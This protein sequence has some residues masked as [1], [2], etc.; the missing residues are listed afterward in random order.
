MKIMGPAIG[1]VRFVLGNVLRAARVPRL[2]MDWAAI[3]LEQA[4]ELAA[5]CAGKNI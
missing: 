4:G 1:R 2:A 5:D 3:F